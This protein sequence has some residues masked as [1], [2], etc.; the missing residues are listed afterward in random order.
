MKKR[1]RQSICRA[2]LKKH[3]YRPVFDLQGG[4]ESQHEAV[5]RDSALLQR[6]GK[7]SFFYEEFIKNEAFF[8]EKE[9]NWELIYVD[10]GS[11]DGTAAEAKSF[12]RRMKECICYP[13]PETLAKRQPSM[14]G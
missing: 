6:G 7:R 12:M 1:E 8:K 14:Q 9:I 10:D 4:C 2:F 5:K 3:L 13:F 11:K